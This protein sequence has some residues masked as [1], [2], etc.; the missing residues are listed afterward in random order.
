MRRAARPCRRSADATRAHRRSHRRRRRART[1]ARTTGPLR[2]TL[3]LSP[4]GASNTPATRRTA[5]RPAISA[6]CARPVRPDHLP[7]EQ[8]ARPDGRQNH[9]HDAVVLLLDDAADNPLAVE[10][11]RCQQKQGAGDCDEDLGV[12]GLLVRGVE[13]SPP[14]APVPAA[15]AGGVRALPCPPPRPLLHRRSRGTRA[16]HRGGA[17][18]RRP[19]RPRAPAGRPQATRRSAAAPSRRRRLRR[20][21]YAAQAGGRRRNHGDVVRRLLRAPLFVEPPTI[22]SMTS[23]ATR[24]T[25]AAALPDLAAGDEPGRAPAGHGATS[26]NSSER[27]GGP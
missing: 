6:S 14:S 25:R 7:G 2:T 19:A 3:L 20:A 27:D 21:R 16:G 10:R 22:R 15:G 17:A 1:R 11:E 4:A 23:V 18:A 8:V 24:N 26:S 5:V 9:L 12:G 13:T